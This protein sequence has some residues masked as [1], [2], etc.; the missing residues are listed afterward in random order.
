MNEP[1]RLD[2][3]A[4]PMR[5]ERVRRLSLLL[6]VLYL[7]G[8]WIAASESGPGDGSVG[9]LLLAAA[10][11]GAVFGLK[12]TGIQRVAG[13]CPEGLDEGERLIRD[14]VLAQSYR[15]FTVTMVVGIV[16]ADIGADIN[17]KLDWALPLPQADLL[18]TSGAVIL[19]SLLLPAA[20]LA[21]RL[22][23]DEITED[24]PA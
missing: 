13:E 8:V 6:P 4:G 11:I 12:G 21:W 10:L 1:N 22:P 17:R 14:R 2:P 24:P 3:S 18:F 20:L 5:I 16:Y 19:L 9:V 7:A 15:I 23:A